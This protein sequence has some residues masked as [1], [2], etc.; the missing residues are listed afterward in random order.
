LQTASIEYNT[1]SQS[2]SIHLFTL[3]SSTYTS[4]MSSFT[5]KLDLDNT[6]L[7]INDT[8]N[9]NSDSFTIDGDVETG[10]AATSAFVASAASNAAAKQQQRHNDNKK[11]HRLGWIIAGA[12]VLILIIG[13]AAGIPKNKNAEETS[14]AESSTVTS[15]QPQD[16]EQPIILDLSPAENNAAAGDDGSS[17][18]FVPE[19]TIGDA[20]LLNNDEII[21]SSSS[22]TLSPSD[23]PVTSEPTLSPSTGTPT[24]SPSGS[25][26]NAPT[27]EPTTSP[28]SSPSKQP[29]SFPTSS[30]TT[31]PSSSPSKLYVGQIDW[32]L[33]ND[34]GLSNPD[35]TS[36]PS[37][38]PTPRPTPSPTTPRPTPDPTTAPPTGQPTPAN[39][40]FF[41]DEFVT[42]EELG[43]Q[44]S[45]GL[46][47]RLIARTGQRV[48]YANGGESNDR[49]HTRS[50]AAG[51]VPLDPK[52]PLDSGYVYMSN[53]E[54]NDDEGGG[55][56]GLYFDKDG[57][58]VEYETL[59]TGTRYN[60]GG[61]LTPWNT[62]VSCEEDEGGQC[63][64]VDPV[65]R[66]AQETK[67]G[68][69]KGG[70]YESVA[71]DDRVYDQ[72]VFYTTEDE[73]DGA[74]RRFVA[75]QHGW[76][77]LHSD[78]ETSFLN[79]LDGNKFE[80]TTDE[81]VGRNSAKKYFPKTEGIQ[82]HEG[83]V[84]FMS[85]EFQRMII[86]DLEN[87]TYTTEST[88][89]KF[90]GEG[91]FGGQPD[92]NMFGP[93][94]KYLYFTEDGSSDPGIYARYHDGTY[95]T[96]FQAIRGGIHTDDETIGIA[97]SPDHK[98][99]YAGFQDGYI[100]EF[101]REDGLRFE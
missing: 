93:S 45:K 59:L 82:V 5:K 42:V 17:N 1:I 52:N 4:I 92:Q 61:G 60:C 86:L 47:V 73:E 56:Y 100:F 26:S 88:G 58:I 8:A 13:L 2:A 6:M 76:D 28:S 97:L 10:V 11:K 51:I 90:Y 21:A 75:Q 72:P 49:W 69:D 31:S 63:W 50:D 14:A 33:L 70:W 62:W 98:R 89:K 7:T 32:D 12:A 44:M 95:F 29:T 87:F 25:P 15:T 20:A 54:A 101:T 77:A 34:L 99:F 79:I 39:P 66:R 48:Q 43:I 23:S 81:G 27:N 71:C 41:G 83:K 84:Y 53:S 94:R 3:H 37:K 57:N 38:S 22:P 64:Q 19:V 74:L 35:P 9:S 80:W 16:D 30:P 65:A 96:M 55:V 78:G 91:S 85:K 24:S 46:N 36:S 67:L 40:Y 68:G 18:P